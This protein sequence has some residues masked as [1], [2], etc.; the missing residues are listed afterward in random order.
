MNDRV[1]IKIK[2]Q[3]PEY[4]I[5]NLAR[6]N[7]ELYWIS[8]KEKELELIIK[9]EDYK[10]LLKNKTIRNAKI[11]EYYGL[12]KIK[13]RVKKYGLLFLFLLSG[14]LLN[15]VL[16]NII[17]KVEVETPNQELKEQVIKDLKELGIKP[18][19][20]KVSYQKREEI[21]EKILDQEKNRIEWL[22]IEEKGTKYQIKVEEKKQNLEEE[23]CTSRNIV[24]RKNAVITKIESS[25][26]EIIK[27]KQDYVTKGEILI[28]GFIHN[29]ETVVSKKCAIGKVY[30]ETW[31]KVTVEI[32]KE[33][34]KEK[35][36]KKK[37]WAIHFQ[38]PKKEI[39]FPNK[40]EEYEKNEYNI[41]ESKIFPV[42]IGLLYLE[43]KKVE[44]KKYTINNVDEKA[45][46]E[47]N[48][49]LEEKLNRTPTILR[50][51]VLKKT[52]KNSKIIVEVFFAIEEDITAYEDISNIDI[53]K[54]N[55][56]KE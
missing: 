36:T 26:G 37:T 22:E 51:N 24:A 12:S 30:G 50:K 15:I 18:F 48:K 3:D 1:K 46:R 43:E 56:E 13:N 32:P 20:W 10:K 45:I 40:Y 17:L 21:K 16:S 8:K 14:I 34:T 53:E 33:I 9:K 27:K 38:L 31:Y 28:S 49:K 54:M 35:K 5:K 55:Q 19:H 44:E 2:V 4:F 52:T 39:I 29:K 7:I 41:I 11:I 42:K 23:N 25:S 6:N 47:A